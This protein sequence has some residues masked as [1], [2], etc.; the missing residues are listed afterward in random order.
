MEEGVGGYNLHLV[1][2]MSKTHNTQSNSSLKFK[3]EFL[4]TDPTQ[5]I[6]QWERKQEKE[7]Q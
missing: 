3:V 5:Y 6:T 1:V 4:I 7:H 2:Q